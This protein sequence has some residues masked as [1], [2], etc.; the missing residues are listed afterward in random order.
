MKPPLTD[1]ALTEYLNAFTAEALLQLAA[2][3]EQDPEGALAEH[4]ELSAIQR[5]RLR[6]MSGHD[7]LL[8]VNTLRTFAQLRSAGKQVVLSTV[9][10]A[11]AEPSGTALRVSAIELGH[12]PGCSFYIRV[13][14]D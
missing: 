4:F 2:E 13:E 1:A 12:H 7:R 5:E 14:L 10:I 11:P 9:G 8:L 6:N 3:F